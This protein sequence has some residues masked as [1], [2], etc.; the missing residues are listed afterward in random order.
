MPDIEKSVWNDR[1]DTIGAL[2]RVDGTNDKAGNDRKQQDESS[3][4]E[5]K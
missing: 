5:R 4:K 1:K 2:K 3:R